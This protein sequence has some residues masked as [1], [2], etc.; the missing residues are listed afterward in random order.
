MISEKELAELSLEG[1]PKIVTE[2][3]GPKAIEA[4]KE[5]QKYRAPMPPPAAPT[6]G[7]A[8]PTAPPIR[9]AVWDE[10]R[11]VTLKDIDGNIF[12]D[13]TAG[14]A[15]SSVGRVH[16]KVVEAAINQ[17]GKLMH[18]GV[19]NESQAHLDLA[20]RLNG[21]MPDGLRDHCF[22]SYTQGGSDAVETAIKFARAITKK[23]QIIG[24]EGAYHGVWHGS[25]ALTSRSAFKSKFGP[26]IPGVLHMPYAY[27]YRCFAGLTY[28]D[29]QM[30]CAKYFDY[31]LNTPGTGA[32]DVAA[33]FIE[34]IQG[35]GGYVD[36]PPEFIPMI[37]AAC[38]KKGVLLI[39][40]EIQAGAGR[41]GKMWAI[42]HYGVSPDILIFG[43]GIGGDTPLAG[44]ALNNDL[45]ERLGGTAQP[46]TFERN[47]VTCAIA[48]TNIALLADEEM[49]L[50]GR[51]AQLGEEIKKRLIEET[52]DISIVGE[53]RGKGLMIGM[54][55]V[56]NKETREPYEN[57][58]PLTGKVRNHGIMV[59]SC[60]RNSNTLRLMPPLVITREYLNKGVDVV[61]DIL[62]EESKA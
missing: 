38:E 29:C 34:S 61:L 30:A 54:E 16:P 58:M 41:S 50:V 62:R 43:K 33:V 56:Q 53:I 3:P 13:L 35:E 44:V 49:D 9:G 36:P 10:G 57:M 51:V 12:I 40:D 15:V 11:G 59:A 46:N 32:D 42:E 4:L 26:L 19:G 7:Q 18:V 21:I 20:M 1:A 6:D 14:I 60:G 24:F 22:F 25:L 37:K 47:A 39:D 27:C 23:T 2:L 17:A 48:A 31:K 52:K 55:L 8:A 5:A 45:S 28:P